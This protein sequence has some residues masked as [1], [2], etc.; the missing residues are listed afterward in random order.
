MAAV[1]TD[2]GAA[3]GRSAKNTAEGLA[4]S[5]RPR[6]FISKTPIS[7]VEPKRFFTARRIR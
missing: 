4:T 5:P 7:L 3:S 6:V 1:T 2:P